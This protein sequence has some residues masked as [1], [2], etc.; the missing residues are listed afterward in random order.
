MDLL[1]KLDD[2]DGWWFAP[3]IWAGIYMSIAVFILA[4]LLDAF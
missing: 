2:A 4:Y 3:L 1:Q